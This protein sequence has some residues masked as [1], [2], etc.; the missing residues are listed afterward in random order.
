M[1]KFDYVNASYSVSGMGN[2]TLNEALK[3]WKTKYPSYEH[4]RRGVIKTQY[5]NDFG[6]FVKDMWEEI[7]PITIEEAFNE[8]NAERRRVLF[9]CI[10]VEKIFKNL[11]PVLLDRKVISK[12]RNR[13]DENNN[14]WVHEFEDEYELYKIDPMKLFSTSDL[15]RW[16]TRPRLNYIAVRC[17]CTSTDREYWIY[18]PEEAALVSGFMWSSDNEKVYDAIKAIAWTIRIDITNPERIYR[19]GDIIV[20]KESK[21]SVSTTPYHLTKDQYLNLMYSET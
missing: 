13:W 6:E 8:K 18:V 16:Q 10:G 3:L 15:S 9:D 12:K 21:D 5:L 2:M 7:I 4:F 14:H 1:K 17:R 19:Q 11:D 20:A